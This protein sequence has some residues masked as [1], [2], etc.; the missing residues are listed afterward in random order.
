M[1]CYYRTI[2]LIPSRKDDTLKFIIN[3][4]FFPVIFKYD[5]S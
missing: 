4:V 1:N 2:R 5:N 3:P